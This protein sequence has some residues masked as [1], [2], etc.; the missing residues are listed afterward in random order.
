MAAVTLP[1]RPLDAAC[2]RDGVP[3]I[4]EGFL[5]RAY[6]NDDSLVP[7]GTSGAILDSP[8]RITARLEHWRETGHVLSLTGRP[9]PLPVQTWCL[10]ADTPNVL[11]LV[12]SAT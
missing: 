2:R 7:R 4:A 5:D 12:P 6:R 11:G 3:F 10:H 1:V 8:E 9:I